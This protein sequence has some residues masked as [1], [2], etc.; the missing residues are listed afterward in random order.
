[1][2]GVGPFCPFHI[3]EIVKATTNLLKHFR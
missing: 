2:F 3:S 1:M